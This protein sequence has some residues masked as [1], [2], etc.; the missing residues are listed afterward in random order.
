[1]R[2]PISERYSVPD[3]Q[4]DTRLKEQFFRDPTHLNDEGRRIF[5]QLLAEALK[6]ILK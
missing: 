4:N 3:F 1:L 5:T 6:P 2:I